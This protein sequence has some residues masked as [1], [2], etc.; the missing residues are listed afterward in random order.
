[1]TQTTTR[2]RFLVQVGG[3]AA[4]GATTPMLFDVLGKN[5]LPFAWSVGEGDTLAAGSPIVVHITMAGGNDYLNTLVP[6]EDPWYRD[7]AA[8]HGPLAL[9]VNETLALA[10]TNYRLHNALPWLAGRWNAVGDVAFALG[11]GNG[12]WNFSHFDSTRFW[13]TANLDLLSNTGW[14]GRYADLTRPGNPLASVSIND[15]RRDAVGSS[16]PTLVLQDTS[17]FRYAPAWLDSGMFTDATRQMATID[18]T[19]CVAEVSK[20]IAT[21]YA[22]SDRIVGAS[23]PAITGTGNEGYKPLTKDLLQVAILIR[24]GMPSQTY[25][26]AFGPFDSHTNQ[27]QMQIDRFNDLNQ[28]LSRFFASLAGHPREQDV[29]VVITSEFGRQITSNRDG[30]TDHGQAGMAMF[31]GG[32]VRRGIFGQAPTLDPGGLTRPNRVND[33]ARPL[34]DFRSVHATVLTRLAKGD[35][36]VAQAALGAQYEDLG[37]FTA[38]VTPPSTTATT[39]VTTTT[40]SPAPTTTVKPTTTT[41]VKPTTTT[42]ANKPPVAAMTLTP[43]S[44]KLGLAGLVVRANASKSTDSDGTIKTYTWEW[45]DGTKNSSGR[46][47]SH[48]FL[49]RGTFLVRLTVKDNKGATS[50]ATGTVTI[51]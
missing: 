23:D 20:M 41:T 21:T 39:A 12:R 46:S 11:V 48:R 49:K 10:G 15:L 51:T 32:G 36:N 27:R 9:T 17:Q 40:V 2:R 31:I 18:G 7:T 35:A 3:A 26:L 47:V 38:P 34:V 19:G 5:G 50:Q 25:S 22:V 42:I 30:G 45:R 13:Q 43:T 44:G 14:L 29:F 8:G 28:G 33:A 16:A 6:V 1:M 24:A 37:V 4:A